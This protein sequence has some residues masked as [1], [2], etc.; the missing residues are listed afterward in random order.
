MHG[1]TMIRTWRFI[2]LAIAG[3]LSAEPALPSPAGIHFKPADHALGDVHPFFDE[4]VCHL[5]YLK[6]GGFAVALARSR[7]LLHWEEVRLVHVEPAP[8]GQMQPYYVLGVVRDPRAQAYR[9]Y[10]GHARGRM[11]SSVST[12]LIDWACAAEAHS[13]PPAEGYVR[14]RDPFVFWNEDDKRYWCV[15]TTQMAGLPKPKAGAV[16]Y[17][18]SA[19]F[20]RWENCGVLLHPGNIDEPE[21]PQ[22]FRLGGRWSLLAS[23]YDR[24][25]GRPSYWVSDKATGPW[26]GQPAGVLDGED[27]CAAQVAWDGARWVMLGWIPLTISK[28]G[29]QPWGGHLALPR[30]VHVLPDGTLGTRLHGQV[31]KSIR[32]KALLPPLE[33]ELRLDEK[34]NRRSF[35]LPPND[36]RL[37]IE[38]L[39]KPA[40]D[41]AQT[42]VVLDASATDEGVAV[43]I[44]FA[45][46]C[47]LIRGPGAEVWSDLPITAPAGQPLSLRIIAEGD[48]VE[49]FLMDRYSLAARVPRRIKGG[50]L[51]VFSDRGAVRVGEM[52]VH[53]L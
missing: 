38:L 15:M 7:D 29:R 20:T 28:L 50:T 22:M 49:A 2:T 53:G 13:I 21:C 4:G 39:L 51:T 32:G 12:N 35:V 26:K 11:V 47:L 14:R 24:A 40:Q 45:H 27:L 23:I 1:N 9:S 42:G 5:Y 6:P 31:G 46:Q 30:E 34:A 48:I 33:S 16:T 3:I 25:V 43:T 41:C 52:R 19:D 8:A 18:T 36:G 44:D 10:Y 37:D 17:A